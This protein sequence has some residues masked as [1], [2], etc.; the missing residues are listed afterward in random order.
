MQTR[1]WYKILVI[2]NEK[3]FS[4]RKV[5]M[6]KITLIKLFIAVFGFLLLSCETDINKPVV[7]SNPTA[8]AQDDL[9]YPGFNII[10]EDSSVTFSWSAASNYGFEASITYVVQLSTTSDFSSNVATLV[11]TQNLSGTASVKDV[12]SKLLS[13]G[14]A[15][16][17]PVKVYYRVGASV[18]PNLATVYSNVKSTDLTPY[19]DVPV[20]PM[21]YVPG[22][23][24]GWS[25]GA[26]NGRLYSYNSNSQYDGIVRIID[27]TNATSEFKIA[28]APNWDNSWG[29]TLTKTGDN[30][31][32]VLDP[33]GGNY[34]VSAACY[35]I[36]VNTSALT[37]TLT[38]T[39]DW[40]IIGSAIPP[41]DWSVDV[42]MFYNG[43]RKMWEI[44][45][46]FKAGEFKLRAN[47]GWDLNYGGADGTLSAG[48]SNIALASDGNYTIR[49]DPVALTY[50]VLENN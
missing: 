17:T 42:D 49:F 11:T 20:Y 28:P 22:A 19:E 48:G 31:S 24:Q 46:D 39:N 43:Q 38:K 45:G 8:P 6:K 12:N 33:S 34:S 21:I 5:K 23:Y 7:N 15:F 10:Y 26:E 30:Y 3:N 32:G 40:G 25:P 36:S 2:K 16:G 18:N 44:T 37:I 9:S 1:I 13:W 29:G 41:Y 4:R 35:S 14:F 27:G 47:D 50:T